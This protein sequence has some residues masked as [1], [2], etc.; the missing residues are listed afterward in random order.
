MSLIRGMGA[1]I[2][3][4]PNYND[5][6]EP[7]VIG[8]LKSIGEIS[9]EADELDSTCLDSPGGY[10][11]YMQGFKDS[12]E[13]PLEGYHDKDDTGQAKAQTEFDTGDNGYY[14]VTLSDGTVIAFKAY[15][16]GYKAGAADA[17]GIV[18][19]GAVLKISGLVQ[20]IAIKDATVQTKVAPATASLDAQATALVGTPSYQWHTCND[21]LGTT[22]VIVAGATSAAY[23]TPATVAGQTKYY[24]C[25]VTVTGYRPVFSQVFTVIS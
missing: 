24:I 25:K 6:G 21:L 15:V 4:L 22:P 9:L 18:G 8:S 19:F 7:I 2:S 11:E 10:K 23:T 3:Y 13:L 12:G 14:W 17:D 16:K 20:V 5:A 1:S